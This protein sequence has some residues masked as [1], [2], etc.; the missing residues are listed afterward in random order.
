MGLREWTAGPF[1]EPC[2]L[3]QIASTVQ[4]VQALIYMLMILRRCLRLIL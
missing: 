1:A 3:L 4:T 2:I